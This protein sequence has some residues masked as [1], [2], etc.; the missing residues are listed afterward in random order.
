M[1]NTI[2]G[3]DA[4]YGILLS[5]N[6]NIG[7]ETSPVVIKRNPMT[8]KADAGG[9]YGIY[10]YA[11]YDI[12]ATI[13]GNNMLGTISGSS[14][15]YGIYLI[16]GSGSI[17]SELRRTIIAENWMTISSSSSGVYGIRISSADELF[18]TIKDNRIYATA[19]DAAYAAY[20]SAS[21]FIGDVTSVPTFF[22]DN[23]GTIEGANRYLLYLATGTPGGG[24]WVKW[25]GNHFTP[26]GGGWA[27]S[28]GVDHNFTGSDILYPT[29]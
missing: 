26:V 5:T 29:P 18:A 2:W 13:K 28:S 12:F 14:D 9:A 27:V 7:S 3:E 10:S 22:I 25:N 17:G 15:A 20:L 24:N 11:N 16:S 21:S 23:L 8:V 6:G 19:A 4:A 1:S